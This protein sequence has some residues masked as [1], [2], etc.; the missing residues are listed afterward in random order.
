MVRHEPTLDAYAHEASDAMYDGEANPNVY[1]RPRRAQAHAAPAAAGNT[2]WADAYDDDDP[3]G[4]DDLGHEPEG[5]VDRLLAAPGKLA[6]GV[7]ALVAFA[8]V[9]VNAAYMQPG[10]HPSPMLSTRAYVPAAPLVETATAAPR[11]VVQAPSPIVPP[12]RVYNPTASITQ[13]QDNAESH[14]G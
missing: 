3:E 4:Y 9:G 2:Q 6:M 1:R 13:P 10:A 12:S 8:V 11:A 5:F 14:A 7:V